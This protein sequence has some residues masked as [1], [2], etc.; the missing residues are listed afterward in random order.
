[1]QRPRSKGG[2]KIL[3]DIIGPLNNVSWVFKFRPP[4]RKSTNNWPFNE[5]WYVCF[6]SVIW[7]F[8]NNK[9]LLVEW[10]E[11]FKE[12]HDD[13]TNLQKNVQKNINYSAK[14]VFFF[15]KEKKKE[16]GAWTCNKKINKKINKVIISS[17][18]SIAPLQDINGHTSL[19][20]QFSSSM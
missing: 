7:F 3:R 16:K 9:I 15:F 19:H 10:R 2:I 6:L 11:V 20:R 8:S 5:H 12:H 4:S 13:R 17:Y 14:K 1:M 18:A